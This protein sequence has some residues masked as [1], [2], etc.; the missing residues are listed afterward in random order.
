MSEHLCLL[1]VRVYQT[2]IACSDGMDSHQ[3]RDPGHTLRLRRAGRRRGAR[4]GSN[5]QSH[6]P[7]DREFAC[8]TFSCGFA[9]EVSRML[10][11]PPPPRRHCT[12]H[13]WPA[14]SRGAACRPRRAAGTPPRRGRLRPAPEGSPNLYPSAVIAASAAR[15]SAYARS[16]TC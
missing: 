15:S 14:P 2:C 4:H 9:F 1:D 5:H 3:A 16:V 10:T 8:N 6:P 13:T 11:R 12:R 7:A